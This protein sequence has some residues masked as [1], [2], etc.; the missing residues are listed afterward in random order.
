[1]NLTIQAIT[2]R[3]ESGKSPEQMCILE[4]PFR[5]PWEKSKQE[6]PVTALIQ[7]EY[8]KGQSKALA[9]R[10]GPKRMDMRMTKKSQS[11]GLGD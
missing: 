3:L 5:Q 6:V 10:H 11:I 7:L 9:M 2:E 8:V 1:M 4:S